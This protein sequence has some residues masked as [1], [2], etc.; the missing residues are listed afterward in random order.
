VQVLLLLLLLLLLLCWRAGPVKWRS[1]SSTRGFRR[2]VLEPFAIAPPVR[3]HLGSADP[4]PC[5]SVER[6]EYQIVALTAAQRQRCANFT[7]PCQ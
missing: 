4:L 5:S 6:G 1:D 2:I 7:A 3:L